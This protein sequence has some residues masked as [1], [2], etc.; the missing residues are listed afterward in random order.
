MNIT[1]T[2]RDEYGVDRPL[3]WDRGAPLSFNTVHE[4]IVFLVDH[5]YTTDDLKAVNFHTYKE[6]YTYK[7]F[8]EIVGVDPQTVFRWVKGGTLKGARFSPQCVRIPHSE[9]ERLRRG[10]P[11]ESPI[12][13][14][15]KRRQNEK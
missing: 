3:F 13:K 14:R 8:S 11:I 6:F 4:W 15:A 10:E 7:E 5:G 1:T 12:K 2:R 9:L